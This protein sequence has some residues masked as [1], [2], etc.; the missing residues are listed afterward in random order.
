MQEAKLP[1]FHSAPM[2]YEQL[3]SRL[4]VLSKTFSCLSVGSLGHSILGR[5][6]PLLTV[7]H[8]KKSILYV[9]AHHG[10]EWITSVLLCRFV[11]EFCEAVQSCRTVYRISPLEICRQ[12]TLHII[13][14]L[15]P[16]GVDYQIHG[17]DPAH[18]LY[19]RLLS[20]NGNSPDFSHW[21]ANARGVDLNHNY[22]A[23]FLEYKEY[24]KENGI[25]CGAP[26]KYSGTSPESEPETAALCNFVRFLS[27]LEII[28]T[29]HTQGE[30]IYYESAGQIPK[31]S[32]GILR[33]IA[34]LTGYTPSR[35]EGSAAYGGMTDWCIQSLGIPSFT[36]ECGKGN[37]PLPLSDA[38]A[39]YGRLRE[40]FFT[41]PTMV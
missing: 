23:G 20:M 31:H 38:P 8:G 27:G 22:N 41:L 16:D 3:E 10:M 35:P 18:P 34:H 9:G 28:L 17:P 11:Y 12:Y 26:T 32:M 7:G 40:L 39:I 5:S 30:E 6:I 21:Q 24:E 36:L 13:P 33:H 2:D 29:L 19:P 37:N 1:S 14:M 4:S 15:N 25:P